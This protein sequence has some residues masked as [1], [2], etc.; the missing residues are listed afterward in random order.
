MRRTVRLQRAQRQKRIEPE[1]IMN[2]QGQNWQRDTDDYEADED[3]SHD[4]HQRQ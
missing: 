4:W 1:V 3:G 2:V